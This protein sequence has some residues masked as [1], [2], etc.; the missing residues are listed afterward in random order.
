MVQDL[1]GRDRAR[2]WGA[3]LTRPAEAAAAA[4]VEAEKA[5]ARESEAGMAVVAGR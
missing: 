5:E 1:A 2:E 3:A 4:V